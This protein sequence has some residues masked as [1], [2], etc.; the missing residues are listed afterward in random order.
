VVLV[1]VGDQDGIRMWVDPH[2][3]VT[4]SSDDAA[5]DSRTEQGVGQQS[6]AGQLD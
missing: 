1:L 6:S 3:R 2:R 5:D 4:R